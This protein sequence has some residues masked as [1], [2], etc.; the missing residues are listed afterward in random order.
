MATT[1]KSTTTKKTSDAPK[2]PRAPKPKVEKIEEPIVPEEKPIVSEEPKKKPIPKKEE[3]EFIDVFIPLDTSLAD[4]DG[5]YIIGSDNGRF[6]K[7]KRGAMHRLEKG[8][9]EYI[10]SRING[11]ARL[12]ARIEEIRY[13][14][15]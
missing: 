2:K 3:E 11:A 6:F 9:A 1:K 4:T 13:K 15:K 12:E 5:Q 8:H 10:L 14:G 7:Y